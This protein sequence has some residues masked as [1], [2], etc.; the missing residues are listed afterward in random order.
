MSREVLNPFT[1][2]P[3]KAIIPS[4]FWGSQVMEN[5]KS[6]QAGAG[7][8]AFK[9]DPDG[10][11]MGADTFALAPFRVD[12]TGHV[13]ATNIDLNQYVANG[14]AAA[15]INGNPTKVNGSKLIA[16]TVTAD[17]VVVNISI[18]TPAIAGGT[19]TGSSI[20]IGSGIT[21]F[22]ANTSGILLGNPADPSFF[23]NMSGVL[24][25]KSAFVD[26][27]VTSRGGS[28]YFGNQIDQAY[29]GNLSA[30]KITTGILDAAIVS[31]INLNASNINTGSLNAA[32]INVTNLNANNITSGNYL[33][34]NSGQPNQIIIR[35]NGSN[36]FLT[37]E[38]GN[39]IWSDEN[40]FMG[41]TA[42]G[43]RFYFYTGGTTYALFQRGAQAEFYAGIKAAAGSNINADGDIKANG[44]LKSNQNTME[45]NGKNVTFWNTSE[46]YLSGST[47]KVKIGGNEKTAIVPTSKGYKALYCMESPE[48]WFMDFCFAT[49]ENPMW[50]FW[51]K[52]Y[53]Y[54]IDPLFREVAVPPYHFMP[55]MRSDIFQVW[56]RRLGHTHKRFGK[57]TKRQFLK[58]ER[59]YRMAN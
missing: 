4:A 39:K 33:V 54:H 20:T 47:P 31:V 27:Q 5:T 15:D 25:C 37:W 22:K 11:W 26:G 50:M 55:T 8:T 24:Y 36:G 21:Q 57:K 6:I 58:N 12:M 18:T 7:N 1:D 13:W 43:E 41:F 29:I 59:F 34:G 28:N 44:R 45:L 51:K 40:Q 38:G 19:I 30:N 2:I 46:F 14:G 48:V 42:N 23:V 9:V 16:G 56:G 32:S 49:R 17:F 3:E 10:M 53:T 35:R 52:Q